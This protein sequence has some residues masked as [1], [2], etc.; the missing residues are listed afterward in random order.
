MSSANSFDTRTAVQAGAQSYQIFSLKALQAAGFPGVAR[1]PVL[2]QDPARE[3]PAPRGPELGP[4]DRHRGAGALGREGG[5]PEGNRVRARPGAPAGLHGRPGG[6]R[7]RRDARR[8][9]AARRRSESREPAA[10]GRARHRSLGAGRLLRSGQRVRAQRG[11]G[12]LAQQGK[13]RVPQVGTERVSELSR[14][15]ARHRHR[16]PGEP[17]VSRA[18]RGVRPARGRGGRVSRHARRHRLAHDD[19]ERARGGGMGRR[20]D[21]S[22]GRHAGPAD[23]DAHSAGPRGSSHRR[24]P[25]GGDRHR[26]GADDHRASAQARRRRQVRRVLRPGPRAPDD[27]RPRDARQHEPGVRRDDRH[28]PDRRDDAGL[29]AADRPRGIARRARRGLR[30]G[31]GTLPRRGGARSRLHGDDRAGSRPDRAVPGGSAPSAGS[32]VVEAREIELQHGA[33][34]IDGLGQEGGAGLRHG[35]CGRIDRRRGGRGAAR[36]GAR[37]RIGGDCRDHQLHQHLEPERDDRRRAAGQE[38]GGTRALAASLGQDEP[39]AGIEG[40]H[41]IPAGRRADAVSR[42]TR[43]Q[44]GGLRLYHVH[45]QQRSAAR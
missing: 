20:R 44:P 14:R 36:R 30:A 19:G 41:R 23:L 27:C 42:T 11:A 21:R 6:R 33:E 40:R 2:A 15:P 29:P 37:S 7:S 25:R 3:P 5:R 34:R 22:R 12:V 31:T 43:V 8:Y 1:L 45:R 38:G 18:R 39:G 28:L 17:R 9:R 35:P 10:A 32:R 26:S 24:P 13:I 16:P 4:E